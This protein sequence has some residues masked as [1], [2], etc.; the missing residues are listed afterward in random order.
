MK[1]SPVLIY[2]AA[3]RQGHCLANNC[4]AFSNEI[5]HSQRC[6]IGGKTLTP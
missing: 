2:A 3:H 1:V 4:V 5:Q 6:V